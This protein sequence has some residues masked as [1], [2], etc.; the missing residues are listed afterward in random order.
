L[1]ETW[2]APENRLFPKRKTWLP[3]FIEDQLASSSN[4]FRRRSR[5]LKFVELQL[6][7]VPLSVKEKFRSLQFVE[8]QL[9]RSTALFRGRD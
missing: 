8:N 4:P 3:K 2:P 5:R 6:R 9:A 1:P 7:S